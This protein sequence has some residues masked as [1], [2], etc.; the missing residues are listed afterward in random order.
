MSADSSC[1]GCAQGFQEKV[2]EPL[3]LSILPCRSVKLGE[4]CH[5]AKSALRF[6]RARQRSHNR[7]CGLSAKARVDHSGGRCWSGCTIMMRVLAPCKAS[8]ART[9]APSVR[10]SRAGVR[11]QTPAP[12][13]HDTTP[14]RC[15]PAAARR[16]R[17]AHPVRP[18]RCPARRGATRRTPQGATVPYGLRP[19][20]CRRRC[21]PGMPRAMLRRRLS[22]ARKMACGT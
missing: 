18:Q 12:R 2:L 8:I 10:L 9:T 17:A 6:R 22:S 19:A 1:I 4:E 5:S 21:R 3:L 20:L 14:S 11:H 15:P 16:R 13:A 7:P